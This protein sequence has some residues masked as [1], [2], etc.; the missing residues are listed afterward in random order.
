MVTVNNPTNPTCPG[1]HG[2]HVR[3]ASLTNWVW[4]GN[5]SDGGI[6]CPTQSISAFPVGAPDQGA[7]STTTITNTKQGEYHAQNRTFLSWSGCTSF[8]LNTC[9]VTIRLGAPVSRRRSSEICGRCYSS[10]SS[11]PRVA[12]CFS[13]F[14][15]FPGTRLDGLG[16]PT[17]SRAISRTILAAE[18]TLFLRLRGMVVILASSHIRYAKM[19]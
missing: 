4:S 13:A 10:A 15:F 3:R 8:S 1:G 9:T 6:Y 2:S 19:Q 17:R 18:K 5:Q 7:P 16:L 14:F 11:L 12:L